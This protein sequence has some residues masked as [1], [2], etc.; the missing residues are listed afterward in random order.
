MAF[1]RKVYAILSVQLI[2]TA[3]LSSVSFFSDSYK[4]WI[5]SNQ[6]MMWLSVRHVLPMKSALLLTF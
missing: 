4:D 1:V 6:W 5:Q 2:A 3:V